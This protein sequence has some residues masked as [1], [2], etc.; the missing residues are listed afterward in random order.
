MFTRRESLG[1][2]MLRHWKPYVKPKTPGEAARDAV[3]EALAIA[4]GNSAASRA[5]GVHPS[6]TEKWYQI[7]QKTGF[8]RIPES[9]CLQLEAL[10]DGKITRVQMRPDLFGNKKRE[11]A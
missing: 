8:P 10:V 3:R 9:R 2:A 11:A 6:A 7:S 5:I 1:V 4:G